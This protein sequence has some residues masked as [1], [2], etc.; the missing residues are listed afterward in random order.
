MKMMAHRQRRRT[1]LAGIALGRRFERCDWWTETVA[2]APGQPP[3]LVIRADI[4]VPERKLAMTRMLCRNT[5][6]GANITACR[7]RPPSL[8]ATST[9]ISAA[10]GPPSYQGR[11]RDTLGRYMVG[12]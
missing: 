7:G 2:Q 12:H 5:E 6:K 11:P 4:E 10:A 3:E 1:S 8:S 9:M